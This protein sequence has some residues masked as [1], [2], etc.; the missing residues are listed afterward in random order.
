MRIRRCSFAGIATVAVNEGIGNASVSIH[1][2]EAAERIHDAVKEILSRRL[3]SVLPRPH[4]G[5]LRGRIE[6]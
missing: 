3:S 6:L 1:P 5:T 2:D 4:A